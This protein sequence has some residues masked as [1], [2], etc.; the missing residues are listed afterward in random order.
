MTRKLVFFVGGA[1]AGKTTLAKAL[2]GKRGMAFFDMDTLLQPAAKAIMTAAGL[3]PY[4]RDSAEYK[5]LC[6]DLGYRITMD[7]ALENVALG[8]DTV[9][10]GPFTKELNDPQW[11]EQEL[12]RI[13]GS[14]QD[15]DVKAVIVYLPD[16]ESYRGRISQRGLKLDEWKLEHWSEFSR[17]LERRELAWNLPENAVLQFD[18]SEPFGEST[19]ARLEDFIDGGS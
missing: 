12:A 5:K 3:D 13:G 17:S 11:I 16:Q 14:L 9:V 10:I 1:G 15:V 18:N 19:L 4:D 8:T 6:R 2:A 7:A